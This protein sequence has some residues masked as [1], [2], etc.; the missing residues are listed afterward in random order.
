MALSR[1][2]IRK[3]KSI[4]FYV[5]AWIIFCA[6]FAIVR[7]VGLE[8]TNNIFP[9]LGWLFQFAV[10]SGLSHGVYEVYVLRDDRFHRHMITTFLLRL[11]FFTGVILVNSGLVYLLWAIRSLPEMISQ[12]TLAQ[13][14]S[15]IVI[16]DFQV[17]FAS[18]FAA[19]FLIT[20]FRSVNKKFGSRVLINSLLGKFQDPTEEER[21]F[22]FLDLKSATTLAEQLGHFAYSSFLRDYF[23]LVSNCCEENRGE[24]YQYA[25]DGVILSWTMQGCRKHPRAL[26]CY[27]DLVTCF[28]KTQKSFIAKYGSYPQFKAAIHVGH[29][30]ATEVGNFGSEMAYHGDALNTTARIQALC[31]ILK[32]DLLFSETFLRKMPHLNGDTPSPQGS[33]QLK[34]KNRDLDV[35]SIE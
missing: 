14:H 8:D 25:G 18:C 15:L 29:V 27:H 33:F 24:I 1:V 21:V 28:E 9:I 23:R 13:I 26:T 19:A 34:G 11:A 3:A 2:N 7:Y 32:K 5:G 22:M 20:F 17:F 12:T 4:G 10:L 30:V 31:N 16:T 6:S 35:F